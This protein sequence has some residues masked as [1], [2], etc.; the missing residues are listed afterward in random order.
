MLNK[1]YMYYLVS[2]E[3]IYVVR[4]TNGTAIMQLSFV[5][6]RVTPLKLSS[7]QLAV[8]AGKN[9][10][11]GG[12]HTYLPNLNWAHTS[13]PHAPLHLASVRN[14]NPHHQSS[15]VANPRLDSG[16]QNVWK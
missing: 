1:T 2:G 3:I 15:N 8:A 16:A 5:S 4:I 11:I 10:C 12:V 13:L 14:S 7:K 6:L 9:S